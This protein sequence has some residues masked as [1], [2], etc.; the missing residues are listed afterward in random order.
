MASSLVGLF[1]S[2]GVVVRL[3]QFFIELEICQM[4]SSYCKK[5][6]IKKE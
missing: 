6:N 5:K 4:L 3:F 1:G 2:S